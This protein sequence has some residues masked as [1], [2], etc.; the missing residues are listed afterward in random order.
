MR[1][2]RT[3]AEV[4]SVMASSS[5][6]ERNRE[7]IEKSAALL[8]ADYPIDVLIERLCTTISTALD[9]TCYVALPNEDGTAHVTSVTSRGARFVSEDE[10]MPEG[11]RIARVFRSGKAMLI[12]NAMDWETDTSPEG[13]DDWRPDGV[14]SAAYVAAS[15]GE[16]V[17]GVLGVTHP[18]P[19][20]FDRDDLRLLEAVARYLAIAVRNQRTSRVASIPVRYPVL[21]VVLLVLGAIAGSVGVFAWAQGRVAEANAH[22]AAAQIAKLSLAASTVSVYLDEDARFA[23]L[24]AGVV[25]PVRGDRALVATLLDRLLRSS[26]RQVNGIG[27]FYAPDVFDRQTPLYGPYASRNAASATNRFNANSNGYKYPRLAWYR[28]GARSHGDVA[29]TDPFVERN[30]GYVSAVFGVYDGGTLRGVVSVDSLSASLGA[31]LR[32]SIAPGDW[33]YVTNGRG[34]RILSSGPPISG[35]VSMASTP[36][37]PSSWTM[38]LATATDGLRA[39]V[40]QIIAWGFGVGLTIWAVALAIFGFLNVVHHARRDA[41]GL[42]VQ[43]AELQSEIATRIEA[44]ERLRSAAYHDTLTGLPNRAFFLDRLTEIVAHHRS[45]DSGEYAVL[46]VDLDR[47]YVVNDTLGHTIGDAL[48]RAIAARLEEVIPP[49]ALIARLGGDEFVLLLP[50]EGS[51]VREAVAVAE[52]VLESLRNPFTIE[53]REVFSGASIGIVHVDPSYENAET[54]LRDADISMYHAKNAGRAGY[55]VFDRSMRDRVSHQLELEGGL[56]GAV[57]RGEIVA[58]YQPIVRIADGT[59]VAFEALA[60][61]DREGRGTFVSAYEFIGVAERTGMLRQIDAALFEQVCG[62][63]RTVLER[64]PDVRFSVNIS[65]NDLTRPSLLA[66][67]DATM[68]RFNLSARAFKIEITETAVMDDAERALAVLG[69]LRARGFEIT[70]DDFGVGYSSLSYLQRLPIGGLKIDRSFIVSLPADGQALEITRAIVALAKTLGLTVTAEGVERRDQL[71]V[72][73]KM[74]VDFAQGFWYSPAI[75]I[76]AAQTFLNEHRKTLV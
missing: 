50:S 11:S 34:A 3:A 12:T 43:R 39:D 56:R 53:G 21:W 31:A 67:I 4:P 69:E 7:L 1:C 68:Q 6:A 63:A 19:D 24:V 65:A 8:A 62:D 61:W 32:A 27:L 71:D 36:I 52:D 13:F 45:D 75:D 9:A 59:I 54:L 44:E 28:L 25:G 23:R 5:R 18:D 17:L 2:E 46:F 64:D 15:Y 35:G 66:D 30:V 10:L 16:S 42:K 48:L 26:P 22:A 51:V 40:R 37:G 72:L 70:V 60:R 74:G 29:F 76:V 14:T 55:A 73:A 20:Q 41:F 57:E 33:A 47:F 58:H 49:T 38:H